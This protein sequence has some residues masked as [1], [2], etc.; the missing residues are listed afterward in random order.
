MCPALFNDV[1]FYFSRE[2][3]KII[4]NVPW[5]CSYKAS[6]FT[7]PGWVG[8]DWFDKMLTPL[9]PFHLV[10]LFNALTVRDILVAS[11]VRHGLRGQATGENRRDLEVESRRWFYSLP[12]PAAS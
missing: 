4:N 9:V 10:L 1:P 12:F 5:G 3:D 6:Y 2:P 11:R 7:D 8:F